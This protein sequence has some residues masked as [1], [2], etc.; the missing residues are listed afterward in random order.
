MICY[1]QSELLERMSVGRGQKLC[2]FAY[3][4][5]NMPEVQLPS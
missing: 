4:L 5:M 2:A 1:I 3:R